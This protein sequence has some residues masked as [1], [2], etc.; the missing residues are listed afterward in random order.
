MTIDYYAVIPD[1]AVFLFLASFV[2][3]CVG[4]V[5]SFLIAAWRNRW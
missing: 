1:W 5:V 3:L 2:V 4:L